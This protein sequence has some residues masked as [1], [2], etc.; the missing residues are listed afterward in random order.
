M[1]YDLVG[2]YAARLIN[3]ETYLEDRLNGSAA[4]AQMHA[5]KVGII[6]ELRSAPIK[7][8]LHWRLVSFT[9]SARTATC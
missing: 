8:L 7:M 9:S 6:L 4:A 5:L 1:N 2:N 3:Q